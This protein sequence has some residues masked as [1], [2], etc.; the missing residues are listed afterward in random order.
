MDTIYARYDRFHAATDKFPRFMNIRR[1]KNLSVAGKL[2]YSIVDEIGEVEEAILDYKKDFFIKSYLE[3]PKRLDK[4]VDYLYEIETGE[5]DSLDNVEIIY[6]EYE[7]TDNNKYFY[8]HKETCAYYQDGYM[9]FYSIPEESNQSE[10]LRVDYYLNRKR[11]S[12]TAIKYYYNDKVEKFA[13]DLF[14]INVGE[15]KDIDDLKLINISRTIT[16]DKKKF[17]S[18]PDKYAFYSNGI[19]FFNELDHCIYYKYNDYVYK[20]KPTK[21]HVWNVFDEFALWVELERFENETNKELMYRA[22]QAMQNR[23]NSSESG[24]RNVMKNTLYNYNNQ[25]DDKEIVFETPNEENMALLN[26]N[27]ET[28]Y[29]EISQFNHDIA[30]TKRW[31]LDYW[32]NS[33]R[34]LEYL[35]HVWDAKVENY[36]DGVG[37]NDSLKVSTVRDLDETEKTDITIE[38]YVQDVE[39]ISEYIRSKNINKDLTIDMYRYLDIMNPLQIQYRIDASTLTQI[40]Y[41][42]NLWFKSYFTSNKRNTYSIEDLIIDTNENLSGQISKDKVYLDDTTEYTLSLFA[43]NGYFEASKCKLITGT[44]ETNL[45]TNQSI[46]GNRFVLKNGKLI[47]DS[48]KFSADSVFDFDT[49]TNLED[50]E[51]GF[52]VIEQTEIASANFDISTNEETMIRTNYS[53][54]SSSIMG[55]SSITPV[56][57]Y[58]DTI[59][60]RYVVS[61]KISET[62]IAKLDI[63]VYAN[64][65]EFTL[66]R[67]EMS[68]AKLSVFTKKNKDDLWTETE[69]D[70]S[71]ITIARNINA[72]RGENTV[73]ISFNECKYIKLEISRTNKSLPIIENIKVKQVEVTVKTTKNGVSDLLEMRPNGTFIVRKTS[74]G[75]NVDVTIVFR[76]YN[77]NKLEIND[78]YATTSN[79]A[80]EQQIYTK[81]FTTGEKSRLEIENYGDFELIKTSTKEKVDYNPY[82]IY[83]NTSVDETNDIYLNLEDFIEIYS[84]NIPIKTANDGRKYISI[85]P[86]KNVSTI[87]IYGLLRKTGP[88]LTLTDVIKKKLNKDVKSSSNANTVYV[89]KDLKKIIVH[90]TSSGKLDAFELEKNLLIEGNENILEISFDKN[91][92]KTLVSCFFIDKD[93][94]VDIEKIDFSHQGNFDYVY[95]YDSMSKEQVAYNKNTIT[96]ESTDRIPIQYNFSPKIEAD[97]KVLF[98]IN[99]INSIDYDFEAKAV[100]Y[101]NNNQNWT[102]KKSDLIRIDIDLGDNKEDL[103]LTETAQLNTNFTVSNYIPLQDTYIINGEEIELG[104]YILTL[105]DKFEVKYQKVRTTAYKDEDGFELCIEPDGFTKLPHSNIVSVETLLVG[106]DTKDLARDKYKLVEEGGFIQWL[107]PSLYNKT[108]KITYQY[109]KPVAI[110]F[111][112]INYMYELASYSLDVYNKQYKIDDYGNEIIYKITDLEAGDSVEIDY[113]YFACKDIEKTDNIKGTEIQTEDDTKFI[114]LELPDVYEITSVEINGVIIDSNLYKLN[115]SIHTSYVEFLNDLAIKDD[116]VITIKYVAKKLPDRI[117]IQCSNPV[118]TA[119][120]KGNEIKIHKIAEDNSL[121]I[122]NGYYYIDGKEYWYFSDKNYVEANRVNG[123]KVFNGEKYGYYLKLKRQSKNYLRNA[124]MGCNVLNAT[125]SFNFENYHSIPNISSTERIGACDSFAEWESHRMSISIENIRNKNDEDRIRFASTGEDSY[126]ILDITKMIR[127]NKLITAWVEGNLRLSIGQE[128]LINDQQLSKSIYLERIGPF[129]KLNTDSTK[130]YYDCSNFDLDKKRYYVIVTGEGALIEMIISDIS[131][132]E[133]PETI[134]S[135]FIKALDKFEFNDDTYD[136]FFNEEFVNGHEIDIDFVP[137]GMKYDGLEMDKSLRL[138][139]GSN[140]DWGITKV[141]DYNLET[142]FELSR[143]VYQNDYLI[144]RANGS[145]IESIPFEVKN[146]DVVNT[147]TIKV[148]DYHVGSLKNFT[149]ELFGS[150]AKDGKYTH[151]ETAKNM[152]VV[153][154]QGAVLYKFIKFRIT[155]SENKVIKHVE[156]FMN[157]AESEN[158]NL[159]IYNMPYGSATTKIFDTGSTNRYSLKKI[160]CEEV[161]GENISYYVRGIKIG[162]NDNVYTKWYKYGEENIFDGYRYFQFRININDQKSSTKIEKIIMGVV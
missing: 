121:V 27:N 61:D 46:D 77:K 1:R 127:E 90:E 145:Y 147:F 66:A 112:D 143:F 14:Y 67:G 54:E 47:N 69:I 70:D 129:E 146:K 88:S 11:I 161:G 8:K 95:L 137:Y 51:N 57:M 73:S 20:L 148:N 56:N 38:G 126:A 40:K 81:T 33:F 82:A 64:Y 139:V 156:L 23:P 52:S 140:V 97:E 79:K 78:I 94:E 158:S 22:I 24:I 113:D 32:D 68:R 124:K 44:Q 130:L 41:P 154:Y 21:F 99:D 160:L 149:I 65:I 50:T 109:N 141:K 30:R 58:F 9:V 71:G 63:E 53:I 136:N 76:N 28:F 110:E 16:D 133:K 25:I 19:V 91:E 96:S 17:Y 59:S 42:E 62:D 35:P 142:D 117:S 98:I 7:I 92:V 102:I 116:S 105:P 43:K 12:K 86:Q 18:N 134:S 144:A 152:N 159:S 104:K 49:F 122:H 2:L 115:N 150:N 3:D 80:A 13:A 120:I 36:K 93:S 83:T 119:T 48:I 89:N 128:L 37:Y 111:T 101:N 107:D 31:D 34:E 15:I 118:Y 125:A 75:E 4:I 55:L 108:F 85:S 6:P 132:L 155:A 10:W 5:F 74:S 26:E 103:I 72:T 131:K 157:Y 100:F 87:S 29:E 123:V 39:K 60:G 138:G 151:L 162:T 135:D 45:L 153:T 84:S 106:S 114:E